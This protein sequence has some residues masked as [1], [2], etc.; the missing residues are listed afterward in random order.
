MK[1]ILFVLAIGCALMSCRSKI[2]F[3]NIDTKTEIDMG[4]ALPIGSV[5]ITLKEMI[6]EVDGLYIDSLKNKGV[7]TWKMDTAI[8]RYYHQMNLAQY[9]STK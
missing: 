3:G 1:K 4:L 9:L 8:E 7:L 5:H 6:G 2:D